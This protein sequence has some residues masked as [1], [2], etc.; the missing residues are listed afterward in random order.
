MNLFARAADYQAACAPVETR[1]TRQR[2]SAQ[3]NDYDPSS[4]FYSVRT[5]LN[6]LGD[7]R[8]AE[9]IRALSAILAAK[10]GSA[11]QQRAVK[12]RYDDETSPYMRAALLYSARSMSPGDRNTC[13]R[14]WGSH[15]VVNGILASTI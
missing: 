3:G 13:K 4:A 1:N 2:A 5:L 7:P 8:E 6:Y 15:N 11:Q 10:F 14:V 9:P 12:L